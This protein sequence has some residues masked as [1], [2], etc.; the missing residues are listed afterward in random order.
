MP[1][2]TFTDRESH[3]AKLEE[4]A[5]KAVS[6]QDL[7][8]IN[9]KRLDRFV[10]REGPLR[11]DFSKQAISVNALDALQDLAAACHLEEWRAKLFAGET[12]NTSED[13]AVLHMALRGVGGSAAVKKEV[14]A[15]RKRMAEFA[16]KVRKDGKF[17]AVVHIGIGGSDLGPRLVADAFQATGEMALD[18]RF[19]ENVDGASIN[20]ALSGLDPKTTLVVVVS[21]SF[22]TQETRMNLAFDIP[23]DQIFDFWDWVGGRYSVWSA[24]GLS[25][26]IAFGPDVFDAFL[27][28]A[29][30]M[31]MHFRDQ[32]LQ[33]NL[34]VMMALTGIWNRNVLG[35]SSQAVIPYARRIRKLAAFWCAG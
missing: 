14:K 2:D 16:D 22:T 34:P 13:R 3:F 24:V 23:S 30:K 32:P 17:K 31:D 1:T 11:A 8:K 25:L 9:P 21:K 10:M 7:F 35:Y 29:A 26:Q 20:D 27:K 33:D 28:G 12:V 19:A 18:L 6:I 4:L 15:M 5:G